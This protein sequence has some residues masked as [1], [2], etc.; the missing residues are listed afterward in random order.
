MLASLIGLRIR[1][2]TEPLPS[3]LLP[4]HVNITMKTGPMIIPLLLLLVGCEVV[5]TTT[6]TPSATPTAQETRSPPKETSMP[7]DSPE[8]AKPAAAEIERVKKTDEEWRKQL[9][10]EEYRILR[11]KGT[12]RAFTGA[13]R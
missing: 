1:F 7:T 6:S 9:T 12:E 3:P 8:D 11:Q 13:V 2:P 4:L 10:D 5:D